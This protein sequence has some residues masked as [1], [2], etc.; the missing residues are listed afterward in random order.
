MTAPHERVTRGAAAAWSSRFSCTPTPPGL[1]L[2]PARSPAGPQGAPSTSV[3]SGDRGRNCPN[4]A[5][6]PRCEPPL[7][8]TSPP[9]CSRREKLCSFSAP[10]A[11]PPLTKI[12]PKLTATFTHL[13]ARA[14]TLAQ[15][16]VLHACAEPLR[17]AAPGLKLEKVRRTQ[18]G[19][20]GR[21]ESWEWVG[22]PR[23]RSEPHQRQEDWINSWGW[24]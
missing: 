6:N 4:P 19:T 8:G 12:L 1:G 10:T 5:S 9:S 21:G 7:T 16:T 13:Q 2:P 20:P 23:W 17:T 15:P 24:K 11:P 22:A 14:T 18:P 3:S